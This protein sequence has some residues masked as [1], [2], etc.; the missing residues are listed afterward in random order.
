[1]NKNKKLFLLILSALILPFAFLLSACGQNAKAKRIIVN[2]AESQ[3]VFANDQITVEWGEKI[4]LNVS[5]FNVTIEFEDGTTKN[6]TG[7]TDKF[8]YTSNLPLLDADL[9]DGKTPIGTYQLSFT[10]EDLEDKVITINVIP[11]RVELNNLIWTDY[12]NF[13]YDGN[14]KSIEIISGVPNYVSVQYQDNAKT[15]AGDYDAVATFGCTDN[16]YQLVDSS[17]HYGWSIQKAS[18]S[19]QALNAIALQNA[20][21]VYDGNLHEVSLNQATMPSGLEARIVNGGDATNAGNYT[22][23]IELL[24]NDNYNKPNNMFL[25]WNIQKANIDV[26]NVAL[27]QDSFEYNGQQASVA[28]DQDTVPQGCT[29]QIISG[30]VGTTQGTYHAVVEFTLTDN[31]YNKP[32]NITLDWEIEK[33][34]ASFTSS[35]VAVSDLYYTGLAQELVYE[36]VVYGGTAQYIVKSYNGEPVVGAEYST[37]LPAMTNAGTY[38]VG[39]KIVGDEY[40][41]DL[42][43]QELTA[44]IAKANVPTYNLFLDNSQANYTGLENVVEINAESIPACVEAQIVSGGSGVNAGN[45][46]A[47]VEFTLLDTQN[48]NAPQNLELDWRILPARL[49]I[50]AHVTNNQVVLGN[51]AE[52]YVS[53][54]GFVGT[55]SEANVLSGSPVYNLGGYNKQTSQVGTTYTVTVSGYTSNSNYEI[56]YIETEFTV[57]KANVQTIIN[58]VTKNENVLPALTQ[59]GTYK[60]LS[61]YEIDCL[62]IGSYEHDNLEIVLDLGGHILS[63]PLEDIYAVIY[64]DDFSS[65]NT[66]TIK[67]GTLSVETHNSAILANGENTLILNS[68]L[69]VLAHDGTGVCVNSEDAVVNCAA[70]VQAPYAVDYFDGELNITGGVYDGDV[71]IRAE[72]VTISGGVFKSVFDVYV[73]ISEFITGGKFFQGLN[74]YYINKF[75]WINSEYDYEEWTYYNVV[76]LRPEILDVNI[77]QPYYIQDVDDDFG[78]YD[79]EVICEEFIHTSSVNEYSAYIEISTDGE[80]EDGKIELTITVHRLNKADLVKKVKLNVVTVEDVHFISDG[81]HEF[82]ANVSSLYD[83]MVEV[84]LSNGD[85]YE[86]SLAECMS[87]EDI[88]LFENQNHSAGDIYTFNLSYGGWS[89]SIDYEIKGRAIQSVSFVNP[90]QC[91]EFGG[92]YWEIVVLWNSGEEVFYD[93]ADFD[94]VQII[95]IN[96]EVEGRPAYTYLDDIDHDG[97]YTFVIKIKIGEKYNELSEEYEDIFSDEQTLQISFVPH[98]AI[99]QVE[100]ATEDILVGDRPRFNY[101]TFGYNN[102][103]D[104]DILDDMTIVAGSFDN[105]VPGTYNVTFNY[106]DALLECTIRVHAPDEARNISIYNSTYII[107]KTAQIEIYVST[108]DD[109]Y[110]YRAP[111]LLEYITSGTLDLT[112]HGTYNFRFEYAGITE[113]GNIDVVELTDARWIY[114]EETEYE[115]NSQEPIQ[116]RVD[117]Y[118]N[119]S[120]YITL[121]RD[122]L[123]SG[124]F[125]DI[126]TVGQYTFNIRFANYTPW[127]DV[128][129]RVYDPTDTTIIDFTKLFTY[130]LVWTY[131]VDGDNITINDSLDGLFI[132]VTRANGKQ[133]ILPV[134]AE[135]FGFD[136]AQAIASIQNDYY[137]VSYQFSY[138]DN[139]TYGVIDLVNVADLNDYISDWDLDLVINGEVVEDIRTKVGDKIT[140]LYGCYQQYGSSYYV[141]LTLDD[142]KNED[143][144][145]VQD[146]SDAGV[147]AVKILGKD[148]VWCVYDIAD[149]DI[150]ASLND[151]IS[152]LQNSSVADLIDMLIGKRLDISYSYHYAYEPLGENGYSFYEYEKHKLV[153][154][155]FDNAIIDLSKVGDA[156][157][158]ILYKGFE[159][160]FRITVYPNVEGQTKTT[161]ALDMGFGVSYV[162]VYDE[163]C[164]VEERW[165][166]YRIADETLHVVAIQ[167]AYGYEMMFVFDNNEMTL[168]PFMAQSLGGEPVVYTVSFQGEYTKLS[169][170][171]NKFA[172]I[173]QYDED[174]IDLEY[175]TTITCEFIEEDGVQYIIIMNV[176]YKIENDN[177]LTLPVEGEIIYEYSLEEYRVEFR[178][179]DGEKRMYIYIVDG[180][181]EILQSYMLWEL[182][183]ENSVINCYQG[184]EIVIIFTI[185]LQL[186]EITSMQIN[187]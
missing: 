162:D 45:Y 51:D 26:S 96:E 133:D 42:A 141:K 122:M 55:D 124:D 47:V 44:T 78:Y 88:S 112:I 94:F 117:Y 5:D 106:R 183:M 145:E 102:C 130:R 166:R 123:I 27:V 66:L 165:Y 43:E 9:E 65:N 56:F 125:P 172:D 85:K 59:S 33:R 79:I 103:L 37:Q 116:F 135:M 163:Y 38:V 181:D 176:K 14:Q 48:Y 86:V 97:T 3:Y 22:A 2:L 62:A 73:S 72:N 180:N 76:V 160:E 93:I 49:D 107:G 151:D 80:V 17:I 74:E 167:Y 121:T 115:L 184:D 31:N 84:L 99:Q 58:G 7:Q 169:V 69:T 25:N 24:P 23:E 41:Y 173:Y 177:S 63:S 20:S 127:S 178:D 104:Q 149:A 136:R 19:Q 90:R 11:K 137:M 18:Y 53:F 132:K 128:T 101:L 16:H 50:M 105:M 179:N 70:N 36:G 110:S 114:F 12:S 153:E 185:D 82:V 139:T 54:Y 134:T 52:T 61:D 91:I 119:Q 89:D 64:F 21:F 152:V 138:L 34:A 113:T 67:N 150:Y 1:M 118:N 155:D 29:A 175:K 120:E 154:S 171:G 57:M 40:H 143:A 87:D 186:G 13:V 32:S 148:F 146:L 111:F 131:S 170:Y 4:D 159:I 161:Y 75:Y 156:Y 182:D 142:V 95:S 157:V 108:W 6:V 92:K 147:Y 98:D 15:A 81:K 158:K 28:L 100:L 144:T 164:C 109:D 126:T 71:L 83:Y 140:S 8:T 35:P 129:I 39:Y 30:G 46:K 187:M 77:L 174:G 10:Y 60:L 68:D 168:T